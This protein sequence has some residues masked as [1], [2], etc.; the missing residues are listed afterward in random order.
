MIGNHRVPKGMGIVLS[1]HRS[2]RAPDVL[3]VGGGVYRIWKMMCGS[4]HAGFETQ[5][6]ERAGV[7]F[8]LFPQ[9]QAP[10]DGG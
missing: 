8:V 1:V 10:A 3:S 5:R 4:P 2:L 6:S 9:A 7:Q